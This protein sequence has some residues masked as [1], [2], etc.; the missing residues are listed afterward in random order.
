MSLFTIPKLVRLTL[1]K[2]QRDFLRGLEN[3]IHLAKWSSVCKAKLK[4][5]LG[6]R[7]LSLLNKA[8]FCKLCYG[9]FSERD[10]L[11]K[12]IKKGKFGEKEGGWRSRVMRDSCRSGFGKRLGSNGIFLI[13]IFSLLWVIGVEWSFEKTSDAMRSPYM[14]LSPPCLPFLIWRRHE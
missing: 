4:R 1:K 5:G 9:F 8:L 2:I 14:R 6:V 13:K 12:K 3:K 7:S 10:L 11:W